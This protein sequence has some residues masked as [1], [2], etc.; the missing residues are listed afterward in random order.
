MP[1][2]SGADKD[3]ISQNI[4]TEVHAGKPQKQAVAI[5]YSKAGLKKDEIKGG[6][7]DDKTPKNFDSKALA[8]GMKVEMEHTSNKTIAREIAMDHLTED[9]NYYKKL[10]EVEKKEKIRIDREVDGKQELDYGTE[11]LDKDG[12]KGGIANQQDSNQD[13]DVLVDKWKKLKKAMADEAFMEIGS[14]QTPEGSEE[15]TSGNE[16]DDSE[17]DSG[18]DEGGDDQDLTPE[19]M[20]MLQGALGGEDENSP[21]SS[22]VDESQQDGSEDDDLSDGSESEQEGSEDGEVSIEELESIMKE[23]GHSD[24][25]IAHVLHG[26]H[27]PDVDE[28]KQEKAESERKHREKEL[29]LKDMEMQ[30][31]HQEGSL[32]N[33]FTDKSNNMDLDQKSQMSKLELEHAKRLK[34]LEFE[35]AK[36]K[37]ADSDDTEHQKRMKDVEY[38]AA[39]KKMPKEE[40]DDSE[41][42]KRMKDLEYESAKKKVPKDGV[43]DT[44]HQKALLD[45]QLQEKKLDLEQKK[46]ILAL[47]LEFKKKEQELKLKQ[48]EETLKQTAKHK[49]EQGDV[50]HKMKMSDIKSPE[51]KPL[52]KSEDEDE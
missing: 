3:T 1:L 37:M 34:D 49:A 18:T 20:Q 6:L 50:K 25:E 10:K 28:V 40:P 45:V 38:E 31:K 17:S 32:K 12:N 30:L 24:T 2:K 41:H 26:H 33:G 21:E 29:S 43:D 44:G 22:D 52:K 16:D 35:A 9:V 13:Y 5:A 4:S 47:E 51:K 8:E 46:K 27:F 7:A 11:E 14:P 19:E 48:M 42:Q 36:K 15:V 23:R 39:K